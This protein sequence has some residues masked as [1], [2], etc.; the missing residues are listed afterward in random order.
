MKRD[1]KISVLMPAYNVANYVGEA[2][3]S[4]LSQS[5]TEFELVI[6][7]D[8]ST[9]TS[10]SVIRSFR[11]ERVV[12]IN[13][14]NKGIAAALNKG[15]EQAKANYIVRFDA[16]DICYHHRLAKQFCFLKENP[17]CIIAG[18]AA[19]YIDERGEYVFTNHPPAFTDG[20]IKR[21]AKRICP[22]IHSS[23]IY[24]KEAILQH[25]GYNEHA[26]SFEDHLLWQSVLQNGKA[27]NFSEPL[28]QVR[29]NAASI[30]VDEQWRPKKFHQIKKRVITDNKISAAQGAQ[31]LHIIQ[32]QDNQEL[33]ESAYYS[34][35]A[36]KFLWNNYQPQKARTNLRKVLAQNRLHWKS[37]CFYALS[38]LPGS[39]L[40]TGYR[41]LKPQ[42][43][44]FTHQIQNNG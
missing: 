34:L 36:K 10:E 13:Q 9:D 3:Q 43:A 26:H 42:T 25:G 33:K 1:V 31:L 41:L 23:V 28:I 11:D 22:F 14:P 37:Y 7:N 44:S 35:L 20:D 17:A 15:L 30:T 4:V 38:F 21:L 16:D 32:S 29:L 24:K 39:F 40:Q 18:S 8:G 12:L 27:F 19:D 2:I 6:I 5:F